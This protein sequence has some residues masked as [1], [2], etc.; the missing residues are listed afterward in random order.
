MAPPAYWCSLRPPDGLVRVHNHGQRTTSPPTA[1]RLLPDD[2]LCTPAIAHS[3]ATPRY[4]T[5]PA[6][7]NQP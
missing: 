4:P 3:T 5:K 1:E 7:T 6:P 2:R